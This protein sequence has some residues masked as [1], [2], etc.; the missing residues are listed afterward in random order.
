LLTA[1]FWPWPLSLALG[2]FVGFG[3]GVGLDDGGPW[4]LGVPFGWIG[5]GLSDALGVGLGEHC[6]WLGG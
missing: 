6:V 3:L 5:F 4:G 2:D 1:I